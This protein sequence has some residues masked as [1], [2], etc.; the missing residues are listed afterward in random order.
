MTSKSE[1]IV[2]IVALNAN[3]EKRIFNLTHQDLRDIQKL[4][5][6]LIGAQLRQDEDDS[7]WLRIPNTFS[8]KD[9]NSLAKF[10]L[11]P[12]NQGTLKYDEIASLSKYLNSEDDLEYQAAV[13][14]G[15]SEIMKRLTPAKWAMFKQFV[16]QSKENKLE[17]LFL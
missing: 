4:V 7:L 1:E 14:E 9:R 5:S 15:Q 12:E 8:K 10:L 13:M 2:S 16:E 11:H 3:N 6:E 17:W